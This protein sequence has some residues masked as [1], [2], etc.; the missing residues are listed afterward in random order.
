[1]E[2]KVLHVRLPLLS[3][4][5]PSASSSHYLQAHAQEYGMQSGMCVTEARN[6]A[7]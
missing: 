5:L 1:M 6:E 2:C 7:A 3:C 4:N